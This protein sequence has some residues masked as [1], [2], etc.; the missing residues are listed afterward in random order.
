MIGMG[1]S[2]SKCNNKRVGKGFLILLSAKRRVRFST[3]KCCIKCAKKAMPEAKAE[4]G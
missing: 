4:E 3:K 1:L 2:K